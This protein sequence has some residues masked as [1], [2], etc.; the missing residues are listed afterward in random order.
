MHADFKGC[1]EII[2][3]MRIITKGLIL[4]LK[5]YFAQLGIG[6]MCICIHGIVFHSHLFIL[7]TFFFFKFIFI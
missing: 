1:K 3:H 7:C 4:F 5:K 2:G 6:N